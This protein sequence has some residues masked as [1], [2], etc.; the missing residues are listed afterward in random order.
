[1][2][3]LWFQKV[4]MQTSP[5]SPK[6]VHEH[7]LL[8]GYEDEMMQALQWVND[9][10]MFCIEGVYGYGKTTFV[11]SLLKNVGGKRK[12]VFFSANRL[13]TS[14]DV[15]RLLYDRFG[16]LGRLLK[17]KSKVLKSDFLI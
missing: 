3:E 4:G 12:A 13:H 2:T 9:H 10:K 16:R 14:L 6:T 8:L 5:L 11:R 17:I 7:E 15:E 1:M